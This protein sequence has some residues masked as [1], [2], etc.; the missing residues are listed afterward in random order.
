MKEPIQNISNNNFRG[1]PFQRNYFTITHTEK[2]PGQENR[3]V[4]PVLP[5]CNK[6]F[7]SLKEALSVDAAV[8]CNLDLSNEN[9]TSVPKELYQ[10]KNLRELN[11]GETKISEEA[12]QQLRDALKCNIKYTKAPV[13]NNTKAPVPNNSNTETDLGT[14]QV[15][16]K[17]YPDSKSLDLISTIAT[18][19]KANS[20]RKIRLEATYTSKSE[21]NNLTR[22]IRT[23]K[24]LFYKEGIDQ[25]MQA[26]DDRVTNIEQQQSN[27]PNKTAS[28]YTG[29]Q[30]IGIN[31]PDNSQNKSKY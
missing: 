27:I 8:V 22:Y 1:T 12:I 23:L 2:S 24:N 3:P 10:F 26:I 29:I 16:S 19:L 14:I 4:K 18:Q 20:N 5:D 9:L 21:Q 7:Y 17:G 30:V 28:G 6:V 15:D 13:P 25:K 11:L 31:F